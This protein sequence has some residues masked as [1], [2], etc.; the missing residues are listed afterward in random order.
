M[1]EITLDVGFDQAELTA[2]M[3]E[4]EEEVAAACIGLGIELFE[5]ILYRSPQSSGSYAA[6]WTMSL[7]V[8]K[9]VDRRGMVPASEKTMTFNRGGP[10]YDLTVGIPYSKGDLPAI[11]LAM[12]ASSGIKSAFRLGDTIWI[13]NGVL[14]EEGE[15]YGMDI[16]SGEMMLRAV[17]RPGDALARSCDY[18]IR[19]YG[20][21]TQSKLAKLVNKT[22]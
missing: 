11:E 10:G 5:S 4:L 9:A 7:N 16:E 22:L 6:S 18:V 21:I 3:N 20:S 12:A 2:L 13:S 14:N 15:A 1:V 17:N 19:Q 8:P